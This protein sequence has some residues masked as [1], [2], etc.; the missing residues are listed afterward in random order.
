MSCIHAEDNTTDLED[1]NID[2]SDVSLYYHNGTRL[3]VG[4]SDSNSTP[5]TNQS[6]TININGQNYSRTTNDEGKTSIAINLVPGKYLAGIYF[7]GNEKYSPAN[8]TVKVNVFPTIDGDD[9]V[10][11]YHNSTQYSATFTDGLGDPLDNE[12]VSFNIHGVFYNRKTDQNGVA[13]LNINL[14]SGEYVLTAYNPCDGYSYSNNITV[15][16]TINGSDLNK[17][18]RDNH[19]YWA[20]FRDFKGDLL[21]NTDVEFNVHGILYTRKTN[22]QG[23]AKLNI[24]LEE[25]NYIITAY[26]PV[27]GEAH[28]NNI[29]VVASSQTRLTSQSRVFRATDD[30]TI[31]ATLLNDLNYGVSGETVKL[32]INKK[33]YTAVTDKNGVANFYLDLKQGNY[34]LKF[35]HD[36]NYRYGASSASSKVEVYDGVRVSFKCENKTLRKGDSYSVTLFDENN[37]RFANQKVYFLMDSQIYP[38]T[39]NK[40]GVATVK[41]NLD[42]EIYSINCFFNKTGYKFTRGFAELFVISTGDT[43][44]I[45]LTDIVTEGLKEKFQVKLVVDNV[46]LA[47]KKVIIN[48]NGVN[49]TKVTDSDGIAKL[50]I[51]LSPGTY[52]VKYYFNGEGLFKKSSGSS[53]LVVKERIPTK[54]TSLAASTFHKHSGITYAIKLTAGKALANKKVIVT[55]A[56]KTFNLVTDSE[57]I[58]YVD[59]DDLNVGDYDVKYSFE[60]DYDY[61]S[62]Q[63]SSKLKISSEIPY[64][65]GYWVRY[66][67]M[68]SVDLASLAAQGTRHI[69]LHSY[70]FETYGESSVLSWIKKAN[71][72]GINVHIWM[73]VFYSGKWIRPVYDDGS[74]KYSYMNS[75]INEAK[76][77]AGLKG[78]AGVHFDYLR[79]GGTA[80]YYPTGT[81]AI[82]YFVVQ[83]SSAVKKVNPN[84]ILSAAVM[85]EPSMMNYYYGQDIPT[86]SKYLDVIMPMVYKGNYGKNT[87]WIQS[88]TKQ[89]VDMSN[90]A[91]IWTGL[92]SYRSDDDITKLGYNELFKDAQAALNGGA[93][94]V[95]MFRWGVTNFIN[96]N[97]LKIS[98]N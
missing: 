92:Q 88:V 34:S 70:A 62:C 74:Y 44:L 79:F 19:Q 3:N 66:N 97:D 72:Y 41:V 53:A 57:G 28:S 2:S 33:T 51:N 47:N 77:Y 5:L 98:R 48:I 7:L 35:S 96:F 61:A 12:E 78:V 73:Q 49:Y 52:T 25:G 11:Y 29:K 59:I 60:G 18:Y 63:G 50:T 82:N 14:E 10:K 90:G 15:L 45:P 95:V 22:D 20:T 67:H 86:I 94:G 75:K 56:S 65:F 58:V 36:A 37:T 9:L 23:S 81:D 93:R 76:Y 71:G 13:R 30:D 40:D 80:H 68:T 89:F 83:V 31:K 27:T 43:R 64:G 54:L 42:P 6:L 24:N 38:S 8:R 85:P 4:L 69:F 46:I 91:Q 21:V 26:N 39:T 1:V 32:E 87:A 55:V 17:I 84:C 16:P